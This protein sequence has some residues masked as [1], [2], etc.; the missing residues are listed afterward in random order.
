[1][2]EKQIEKNVC[3]HAKKHG[4]AHYKFNSPARA[5]VPDRM[6]IH[7]GA[8]FFIE[9][10]APGKRP[11]EPQKREHA[12]LRS[13]GATVFVVDNINTGCQIIDII[14]MGVDPTTVYEMS[15]LYRGE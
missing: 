15:S 4:M 1:M 13:H 2:L 9:F 8:V 12:R 6:L 14:C 11:T 7:N 5:A 3:K 10:K